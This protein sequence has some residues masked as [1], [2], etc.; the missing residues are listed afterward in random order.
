MT[1]WCPIIAVDI[2]AKKLKKAKSLGATHTV[3]SSKVEPVAEIKRITAETFEGADGA[4][5]VIE[6]VGRPETG[7]HPVDTARLARAAPQAVGRPGGAS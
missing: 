1:S 6:A 4:D 3:D 2:D 7:V 5:V